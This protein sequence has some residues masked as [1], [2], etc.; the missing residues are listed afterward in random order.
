MK[1]IVIFDMECN[2][3]LNGIIAI[4]KDVEI[5]KLSINNKSTR[6][7]EMINNNTPFVV[8]THGRYRPFYLTGSTIF[9][10]ST[11]VTASELYDILYKR[12]TQNEA[13]ISPREILVIRKTL[14]GDSELKISQ[15][16]GVTIK[17]VSTHKSN[18]RKKTTI[19]SL[20]DMTFVFGF[21][22]NQEIFE[23]L[24]AHNQDHI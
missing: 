11:C 8:I 10:V 2:Y 19:K 5:I 22:I 15:D 20:K 16:I 21:I 7:V 6:I 3:F 13:R 14:N 12:M 23:S 9:F 4:S 18:I 17:T 1:I 24:H